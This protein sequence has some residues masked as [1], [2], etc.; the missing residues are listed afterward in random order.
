MTIHLILGRQGSGKTLFLVKLALAEFQKK[1]RKIYANFKLNFDFNQ[2]NYS[3]IINCRL[4]DC[5]TL[6]DEVHLIL[7]ARLS[8]RA[9]NVEICD[10]FLSMARKQNNEIY[11]TTQ[12]MRKVDIRFR[13]EADY[14]YYCTKFAYLNNKWVEVL[15]DSMT[16]KETPVM[17]EVTIEETFSGNIIKTAFMGNKF[18]DLFDTKEIIRIKGLQEA[19]EKKKKK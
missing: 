18:Y 15:H 10:S 5:I 2:I 6:L 7:P 16:K 11:G 17:I 8:M 4:I 13:E 1:N 3:D 14:I 9:V 12:T 19:L